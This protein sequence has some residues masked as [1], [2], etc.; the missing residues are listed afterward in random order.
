MDGHVGNTTD[1]HGIDAKADASVVSSHLAQDVTL[2]DNP[3]GMTYEEGEWTPDLRFG[4]SGEGI[5]YSTRDG[6]YVKI[7]DLI[8]ITCDFTLSSKGTATGI[9]SIYGIPIAVGSLAYHATPAE[10]RLESLPENVHIGIIA[11]ANTNFVRPRRTAGNEVGELTAA[12]FSDTSRIRMT[13][14]YKT[15]GGAI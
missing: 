3:H 9:A 6:G 10:Y 15:Q 8:T 5:T 2:G 13:I 12:N 11:V 1:A 14:T 4:G 7:N